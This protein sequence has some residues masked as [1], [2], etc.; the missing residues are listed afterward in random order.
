LIGFFV[1]LKLIL[2]LKYT[3]ILIIILISWKYPLHGQSQPELSE[4]EKTE[5]NILLYHIKLSRLQ[6]ILKKENND[7]QKVEIHSVCRSGHL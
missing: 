5:T 6:R 4:E 7:Q 3:I 2:I 1:P